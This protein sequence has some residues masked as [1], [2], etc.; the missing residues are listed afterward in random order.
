MTKSGTQAFHG[1]GY[2]YGRRPGLERQQLDQ[3]AREAPAPVGAER[4]PEA[5]SSR[6]DHGYTIGGPIF[7]PGV[8]N[9]DKKKLFFFWSQEFQSR[10]RP[11]DPAHAAGPHGPGAPRRL[12]AERGQ[13]RQ[14]VP[15]HP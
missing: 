14:P 8:F 1:S 12:L 13:Q 15:V 6:N 9:T 4:D 11:R 2:W 3:Q 5:T 10:Y 7:I